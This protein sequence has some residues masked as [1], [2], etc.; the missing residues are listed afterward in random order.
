V[1]PS[2]PGRLRAAAIGEIAHAALGRS[3]GQARVLA[4]LSAST[5]LTVG[6]EIVWL[7]A[8]GSELHPRA[9][10]AAAAPPGDEEIVRLDSGALTPWQPPALSLERAGAQRLVVG[11]RRLA[12]A[13][14]LGPVG[15]FGVLVTGG[16]LAFPLDGARDVAAA[17]ADACARD[18]AAAG[19]EAAMALL[20]LGGGLTPSG[21]DF[22]GG[23]LFARGL[24][25][26]A[27][28]ADAA[29]W[30]RAGEAVCRAARARTHP[31][32]ATLLGDLV[33]GRGWASLHELVAALAAGATTQAAAAARR[34]VRLGHTS[35]W[36][37][38]AGLGAGLGGHADDGRWRRAV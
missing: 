22:V 28:C 27:R 18:D 2:A 17:L 32:S 36:D 34:L 4:R 38:L 35:G 23:A 29:A 15:G 13:A 25:G 5:Y 3:G 14:A 31:I 21:D 19:A 9:I 10:L 7:G 8:V 20:G 16:A 30:R 26:A 37:L 1:S 24:L 33:A 11:W 6:D 12:A